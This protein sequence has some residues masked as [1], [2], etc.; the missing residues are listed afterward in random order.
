MT[1]EETRPFRNIFGETCI[2]G[3]QIYQLYCTTNGMDG[4]TELNGRKGVRQFR[5]QGTCCFV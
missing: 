5:S 2:N 1:M 4:S 3:T